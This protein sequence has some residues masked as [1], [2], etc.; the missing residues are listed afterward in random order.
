VTIGC[1][2]GQVR[3]EAAAA[4][5]SGIRVRLAGSATRPYARSH[6]SVSICEVLTLIVRFQLLGAGR[7]Y[8][9]DV[10]LDARV[11]RSK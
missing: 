1:E 8:A 11:T 5:E 10:N 2:L 7:C 6:S 9:R 3:K 4:A